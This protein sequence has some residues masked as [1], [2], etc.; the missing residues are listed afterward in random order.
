MT[1]TACFLTSCSDDDDASSEID[2]PT[3]GSDIKTVAT[4]EQEYKALA[5]TLK[6]NYIC[7]PIKASLHQLLEIKVSI[8]GQNH[9]IEDVADIIQHGDYEFLIYPND[10]EHI[11]DIMISLKKETPTCFC[12]ISEIKSDAGEHISCMM[13]DMDE[14]WCKALCGNQNPVEVLN[15]MNNREE[16]TNDET[17]NNDDKK[18]GQIQKLYKEKSETLK[19]KYTITKAKLFNNQELQKELQAVYE[20]TLNDMKGSQINILKD[21]VEANEKWKNSRR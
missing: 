6:Y 1:L 2:V 4:A 8:K 11:N 7:L 19:L 3:N 13:P 14:L 17:G 16:G 15:E 21:L 9:N 20:Q 10:I 5:N 12:K 18:I